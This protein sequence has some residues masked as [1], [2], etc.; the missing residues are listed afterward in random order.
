M[1]SASYM[2]ARA[3]LQ[4]PPDANN[5]QMQIVEGKTDEVVAAEVVQAVPVDKDLSVQLGKVILR[6]GNLIVLEPL[7]RLGAEVR[8]N[9]RMPVDFDTFIYPQRGGRAQARA[10][11][12]SCGGIAFSSELFLRNE[13]VFEIVIPVTAGGPLIVNAGVLRQ[14]PSTTYTR[15]YAAKFVDL[16][17]D[18]EALIREAVFSVQLQNKDA[19]NMARKAR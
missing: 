8:Q 10:I 12:L 17:N 16:I 18:E 7:R 13:E 11:D 14:T 4:S 3:E 1:N 19:Y 15:T 5:M 2:L 9:L 6:R